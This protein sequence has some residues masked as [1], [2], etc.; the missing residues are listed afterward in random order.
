MGRLKERSD[1]TP[2]M[3]GETCEHYTA[4]RRFGAG[5]ALRLVRPTSTSVLFLSGGS[6]ALMTKRGKPTQ[7]AMMYQESHQQERIIRVFVSSTFRDMQEDRDYLVKFVFPRLRK[8]CESRGVSWGEVDLRWGITDEEAAEGQVLP[9]CLREIE[10]CRPFFIGLLGERYG[11]VPRPDQIPPDLLERESWLA[12]H[13]SSSVTELEFMHGVLRQQDPAAC[14][15][16]RDPAYLDRL[17]NNSDR[18]NFEC[19]SPQSAER[20]QSLKRQ[21]RLAATN[22]AGIQLRENYGGVEELGGWI[23]EDLTRVVDERFPADDQPDSLELQTREH[24]VFARSRTSVYIGGQQS[25]QRL[26]EHMASAGPPLVI[27]GDSGAGKSA[28]LANWFLRRQQQQAQEFSLVHFIGGAPNSTNCAQMLQRM[29]LEMKRRFNISESVPAAQEQIRRAFPQWLESAASQGRVILVIDALDQLEDHDNARDL[30]W[31]PDVLPENCR[32]ILSTLPGRSL[33]ATRQRHWS[34]LRVEPLSIAER[35]ELIRE[36]LAQSRRRLSSGRVE[37]IAAASQC[38]NPLF[39]RAMLDELRQFGDHGRLEERIAHYLEAPDVEHLYAL[40][41]TRWEEDFGEPLVRESLSAL[42]AARRGLSERELLDVLAENGQA[43]PHAKWTPLYLAMESSLT[44]RSGLLSFFHDHLRRAV[45]ARYLGDD[46]ARISGHMRLGHYFAKHPEFAARQIDELPWQW[47]SA[48]KW[49]RLKNL[50]VDMPT[51]SRLWTHDPLQLQQYWLAIGDVYDPV[52][53]YRQAL[54]GLDETIESSPKTQHQYFEVC[55]CFKQLGKYHDALALLDEL[56]PHVGEE[57]SEFPQV[58]TG[59][60]RHQ[61]L[62]LLGKPEEAHKVNFFGESPESEGAAKSWKEDIGYRM[63]QGQFL[64]QDEKQ[65]GIN[66][67]RVL[68]WAFEPNRDENKLE[69]GMVA[70]AFLLTGE[71]PM[72]FIDFAER[73]GPACELANEY[74]RQLAQLLA[75]AG[76]YQEARQLFEEAV[77]IDERERGREHSSTLKSIGALAGFHHDRGNLAVAEKKYRQVLMISDEVWGPDHPDTAARANNLAS[78]LYSKG[79]YDKAADYFRDAYETAEATWGK[80]NHQTEICRDSLLTTI[81]QMLVDLLEKDA[82]PSW[83]WQIPQSSAAHQAIRVQP[84]LSKLAE[85]TPQARLDSW[86]KEWNTSGLRLISAGLAISGAPPSTFS[87]LESLFGNSRDQ[88]RP[89]SKAPWLGPSNYPRS[90]LVLGKADP[91]LTPDE[92]RDGAS[93][94]DW[95][96]YEWN[97]ANHGTAP[98]SS[99]FDYAST[100]PPANWGS[101]QQVNNQDTRPLWILVALPVLA[102]LGYVL[103]NLLS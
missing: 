87:G 34:E 100:G 54:A 50:L 46:A 53:E 22:S 15:Y 32:L 58:E 77:V 57:K 17:P 41:L 1:A 68:L 7:T 61:L 49:K 90:G 8:L 83:I 40:V 82:K 95:L 67:L 91:S 47:M 66:M 26:D 19:E 10:F 4:E 6:C 35:E 74:R 39:L 31:L 33:K 84:A 103:W 28:L 62:K 71:D 86:L 42:S 70:L 48:K 65:S 69:K 11:W 60:L 76:E 80:D 102:F 23:L 9:L 96:I 14:I 37:K 20:L 5:T 93:P 75:D 78:V 13:P 99:A 79:Q 56:A 89:F 98:R 85:P 16:F 45:H 44:R 55:K 92:P 73:Q 25:M 36:F 30:N 24:L 43:L 63:A 12:K 3:G 64:D 97:R 94:L 52:E 29:M 101:P 2:A 38:C 72:E 18:A 51:F 59:L 88:G 21:L 27:T 81:E